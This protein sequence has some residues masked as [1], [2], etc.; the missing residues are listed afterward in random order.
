[1]C[2][3]IL[4]M[5]NYFFK[6]DDNNVD[7]SYILLYFH[8]KESSILIFLFL[9]DCSPLVLSFCFSDFTKIVFFVYFF[10]IQ[11]TCCRFF[12]LDPSFHLL[13]FNLSHVL[14]WIL[15]SFAV[16]NIMTITPSNVIY[17]IYIHI[18]N[19]KVS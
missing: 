12:L 4:N 14:I 7:F 2:K 5:Y 19:S 16:M 6:S 1:M 17:P 3:I 18:V 10:C 15:F 9:V 11:R 8:V 13:P